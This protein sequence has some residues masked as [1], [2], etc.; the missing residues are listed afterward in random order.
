[1][2]P[3]FSVRTTPRFDRLL[4]RL[5]KH[6]GL[7]DAYA[8]AFEILSADPYSRTRAHQIRKLEDVALGEGQYRLRIGR[9]R[10]RY[11]IRGQNVILHSC[12]LRR[13]DTYR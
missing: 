5:R 10:I 2:T 4:H 8:R 11:D 7:T 13:E 6:P 9:W 3:L 12:S 1:M